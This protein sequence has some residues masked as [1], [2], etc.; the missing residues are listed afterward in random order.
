[1]KKNRINKSIYVRIFSVFLGTY[2]LLMIGFFIFFV[3]Q[4]KKTIGKELGT[5]SLQISNRVAEVLRDNTD[6]NNQ[7]IDISKVKKEFLK[8]SPAFTMPGDVEVAIF[9]GDYK[10]IYNTNDYW[11]CSYTEDIEGNTHYPGY[12]LLNPKDW[13]SEEEVRELEEYLYTN[14]KAEKVGD[15]HRYSLSI[16]GFWMD[17]EMII[18]DKIYVT[19]IYADTFDE[20]GSVISAGGTRRNDIVYSSI[21]IKT[22]D[23]PYFEHGNIVPEYNRNHHSDNQNEIRQMVTD[24]SNLK[25]FIQQLPDSVISNVRVNGLTYRYYMLVPY[26][27]TIKVMDD[28][29]L[30][31]HFWTTAGLDINIWERISS[32][33]IY[34][35]VSCLLIFIIAA[36]IL[37]RQT[38]KTHL[39][40]EEIERE[41]KEIT[42]AFAHDLKTPLSIIS[43]Y[44]QNLQEDIHTEKR[45]YYAKNIK[46]NVD[47]MDKIIHK[48]L[49]MRR[50][51]S[52][53]FDIELEEI[54]LSEIYNEIF[55]RYKQ[56]CDERI[57][58]TS[59]EGD[60]VISAD[61]SL[62]ER[63][64]DNFFINAI[65]N[66]PE[67]GKITMRIFEDTLEVYNSGSHIP[68]D[69]IKEIW[70]PYKKGNPERSNTKGTGLGLAISRSILELHKFSYGAK[71]NEDGVTFW[72]KWL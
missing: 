15:L 29:S 33:L 37:S 71:N 17:E 31:S 38:Y 18:P 60:A 63:V 65:D 34:V 46:S 23:L 54:S 35:W 19:P 67:G 26:Q 27:S 12:G 40:R 11:R 59:L 48:M 10:L 21:Y 22:K 8:I 64:I 69:K 24:Q 16:E 4:E 32:T 58:T 43:G 9:T 20:D 50:L 62:M 1:M 66:T 42:D 72:F 6:N 14:P 61:K 51:E 25:E 52:N 2:L 3:S 13:F 30:Y 5:Y 47:R 49:E 56:V 44:T 70:S 53:S 41:R 7:I 28:Q 68:E 57:I 45:E 55:S 36:L 39:K